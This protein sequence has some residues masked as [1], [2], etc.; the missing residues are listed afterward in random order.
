M[1][2]AFVSTILDLVWVRSNETPSGPLRKNMKQDPVWKSI[3]GMKEVSGI[4]IWSRTKFP[5]YFLY[6]FCFLYQETSLLQYTLQFLEKW[7]LHCFQKEKERNFVNK[8]ASTYK[9]NWVFVSQFLYCSQI[10]V[11]MGTRTAPSETN[12]TSNKRFPPVLRERER[13]Q[14]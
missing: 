1:E 5:P 13:S 3:L 6:V 4:D 9:V 8:Q 7:D 11:T 14:G 12:Y 10:G 2:E